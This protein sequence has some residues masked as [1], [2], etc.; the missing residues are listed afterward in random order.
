MGIQ[1]YSLRA[2]GID[3][4]EGALQKIADLGLHWVEFFGRHYP[5]TPDKAK[6]AEMNAK[7]FKHDMSV[8]SHGVN[9]FGKNQMIKM[10]TTTI[11][12]IKKTIPS[13]IFNNISKVF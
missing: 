9:A 3:G 10:R 13:S 5:I 11:I 6:I 7:L 2:F 4:K 8:S 12:A 1:S